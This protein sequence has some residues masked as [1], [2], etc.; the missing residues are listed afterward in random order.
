MSSIVIVD[1][2]VFLN[3]LNVPGLNDQWDVVIEELQQLVEDGDHLF[4][5]MA[6]IVETGN[7]IAQL[8]NGSHRRSAAERFVSHVRQALNDEAPWK[9]IN[10][11]ANHEVLGWLDTFT[12]AATHGMGVGD[13]SIKKEWEALCSKHGMS[14][15]RV[16]TLDAD[17]AG[18]DRVPG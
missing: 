10:F 3:I 6:A 8:A 4:I 15:V 16:W 2:S 18:L 17:L 14:R 7:H 5:P 12:D 11:P 9:P 1:T 13:L